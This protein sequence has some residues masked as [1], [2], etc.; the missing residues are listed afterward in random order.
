MALSS[1]IAVNTGLVLAGGAENLAI[2]DAVNVAARLEQGGVSS[3]E[4]LLG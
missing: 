2:G 1:R 3:G 4:I